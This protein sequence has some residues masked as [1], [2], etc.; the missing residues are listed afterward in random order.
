MEEK[1]SRLQD[2]VVRYKSEAA[3]LSKIVE[4]VTQ[5]EVKARLE[6]LCTKYGYPYQRLNGLEKSSSL[7][8]KIFLKRRS[9]PG[10][11]DY[12]W[13]DS[14]YQE[15]LELEHLDESF[16]LLR[17]VQISTEALEGRLTDH[18]FRER[19]TNFKGSFASTKAD[20]K[21]QKRNVHMADKAHRSA[22]SRSRV[23]QTDEYVAESSDVSS[24]KA[25]LESAIAVL[26]ATYE[27]AETMLVQEF[28]ADVVKA[29]G[30][31]S[32]FGLFKN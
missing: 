5:P 12:R 30:L 14:A 20:L 28:G 7:F 6:G 1:M 27:R 31:R 26:E 18:L 23:A 9:S 21:A 16:D 11:G 8:D 13:S 3:R 2:S 29:N 15:L 25:A 32:Y 22:I 4:G 17:S 10:S 19:L 24:A